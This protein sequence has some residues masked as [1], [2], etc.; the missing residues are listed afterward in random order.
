MKK[1]P[2]EFF[3]TT[4]TMYSQQSIFTR[5]EYYFISSSMRTTLFT[6]NV[7]VISRMFWWLWYNVPHID[8]L[9]FFFSA[10]FKIISSMAGRL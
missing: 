9:F 1:K 2:R 8:C 10:L 7:Q 3:G 4:L 5:P 6:E